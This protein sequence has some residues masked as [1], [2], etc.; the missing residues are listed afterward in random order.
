MQNEELHLK[1]IRI[2][3]VISY[4]LLVAFPAAADQEKPAVRASNGLA[5]VGV[6]AAG[7]GG[8]HVVGVLGGGQYTLPISERFGARVGLD[9]GPSVDVNDGTVREAVAVNVAAFWRRPDSFF[10]QAR[11]SGLRLADI[12]RAGADLSAGGYLES[13]DYEAGFAYQGGD[14]G[15]LLGLRAGIGGYPA[16]DFRLRF[17]GNVGL[18]DSSVSAAGGLG[19]SWQPG[20]ETNLVIGFTSTAGAFDGEF[21]Y[22]GGFSATYYFGERRTLRQKIREDW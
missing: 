17:E 14:G 22:Q 8:D 7:G 11:A 12:T 1:P 3:C 21:F 16:E 15:N 6:S 9:V 18:L 13:W 20:K 2:G 5:R 19:A 10:V 4:L